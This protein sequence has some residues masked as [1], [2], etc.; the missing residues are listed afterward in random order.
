VLSAELRQPLFTG[1][2]AKLFFDQGWVKVSNDNTWDTSNAINSYSLSSTG[3][4]LDLNNSL[5]GM[6]IRASVTYAHS[7]GDNPA[8]SAQGLDAEGSSSRNR[9]WFQLEARF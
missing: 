1:L 5:F 9:L 7:I 2:S 8:L 3:V 6:P 4:G